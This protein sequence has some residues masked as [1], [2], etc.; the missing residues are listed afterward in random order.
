MRFG[1][2]LGRQK[3]SRGGE[4]KRPG[5]TEIKISTQRRV[6][7][8]FSRPTAKFSACAEVVFAFRSCLMNGAGVGEHADKGQDM[9]GEW[10][11]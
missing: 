1:K 7:G 5:K 6:S 2:V 4:A 9:E 8:S 3:S 11:D 10:Q